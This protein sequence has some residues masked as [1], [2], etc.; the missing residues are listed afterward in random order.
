MREAGNRTIIGHGVQL[1]AVPLCICVGFVLVGCTVLLAELIP[2]VEQMVALT[3]ALCFSVL[4]F[5]LPA[6]MYLKLQPAD[7]PCP[8]YER[9]VA[10][11][12]IP[13][14]VVGAIGGVHGALT[15]HGEARFTSM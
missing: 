15:H 11:A 13:L 7:T 2:S 14:G 9:I 5:V 10:W 12:L 8:T 1:S 3:G 4:C 6:A